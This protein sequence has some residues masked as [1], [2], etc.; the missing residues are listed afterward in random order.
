MPVRGTG[1]SGRPVWLSRRPL[2]AHSGRGVG[3]RHVKVGNATPRP[4]ASQWPKAECLGQLSLPL[5]SLFLSSLLLSEEGKVSPSLPPVVGA[6]WCQ[7]RLV[8]ELEWHRGARMSRPNK[9]LFIGSDRKHAQKSAEIRISIVPVDSQEG[10]VDNKQQTELMFNNE[11]RS[12][13]GRLELLRRRRKAGNPELHPLHP[14][15]R[16]ERRLVLDLHKS[17]ALVSTLHELVSTHCPKT[18]QKVFWEGL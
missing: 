14:L 4:V 1:V 2:G 16:P 10:A 8:A 3:G 17:R 15:L 5:F 6:W 18:A 11:L 12:S 7:R 13:G 9:R